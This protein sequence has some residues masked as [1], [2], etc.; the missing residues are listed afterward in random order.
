MYLRLKES[1]QDKARAQLAEQD[2]LS[3]VHRRDI[4]LRLLEGEL[5]VLQEQLIRKPSTSDKAVTANIQPK[6]NKEENKQRRQ[7]SFETFD[8]DG[9]GGV[10]KESE[11]PLEMYMAYV[12][13]KVANG[14]QSVEL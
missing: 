8:E 3:E 1:E 7:V 5:S 11:M 6:K 4:K 13:H 2:A 12:Y 14:K 9:V 10:V